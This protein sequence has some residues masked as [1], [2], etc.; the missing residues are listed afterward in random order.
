[1]YRRRRKRREE[2]KACMPVERKEF[3]VLREQLRGRTGTSRNENARFVRK[4]HS[5]WIYVQFSSVSK[6]R[7]S[8]S[9]STTITK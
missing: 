2:K 9:A 5:G 7:S 6:P 4:V 8:Y 1:V 3:F